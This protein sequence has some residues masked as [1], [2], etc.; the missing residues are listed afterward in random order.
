MIAV[1]GMLNNLP[2]GTWVYN[3]ICT[4]LHTLCKRELPVCYGIQ[5]VHQQLHRQSSA[6]VSS[7]LIPKGTQRAY[8]AK[9]ADQWAHS[10]KIV[11]GHVPQGVEVQV[12]SSAHFIVTYFAIIPN[13]VPVDS[14][15][16]YMVLDV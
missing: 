7:S 9:H 8:T 14:P 3:S 4:H 2:I 15:Y 16:G 13:H 10:H 1:D 12:L 5:T 6:R 11:E